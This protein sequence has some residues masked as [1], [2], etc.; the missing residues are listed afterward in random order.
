M[1]EQQRSGGLFYQHLNKTLQVGP[2]MMQQTIHIPTLAHIG[3]YDLP[4]HVEA[5]VAKSGVQ[6]GRVNVYLRRAT[7]AILM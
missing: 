6:T 1:K 4:P 5:I 2:L 3:L 7:A